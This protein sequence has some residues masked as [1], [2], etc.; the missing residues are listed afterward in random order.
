[1]AQNPE[2]FRM[3][4]MRKIVLSVVAL[5]GI[6]TAEAQDTLRGV[7]QPP[8]LASPIAPGAAKSGKASKPTLESPN[9]GPLDGGP[10]V[11]VPGTVSQGTQLP[12]DVRV[13]HLSR[14]DPAT[15]PPSS[16]ATAPS[17]T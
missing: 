3:R 10:V 15:V 11:R 14:V 6:G 16:T 9:Y 7:Y 12:N 1:M 5:V 8:G 2:S 4:H 13:R 17:W